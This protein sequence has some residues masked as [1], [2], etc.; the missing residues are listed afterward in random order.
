MYL[1]SS[2]PGNTCVSVPTPTMMFN[3]L[4]DCTVYGYKYSHELMVDFKRE[5][6]NEKKAYTKFMCEPKPII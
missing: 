1:C 4:Y 6:V 5:F 3:D 2:I